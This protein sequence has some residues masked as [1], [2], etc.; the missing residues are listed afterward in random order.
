MMIII[1]TVALLGFL[2]LC[3]AILFAT[4]YL[5]PRQNGEIDPPP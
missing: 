5:L 4:P 2:A 3:A 1:A